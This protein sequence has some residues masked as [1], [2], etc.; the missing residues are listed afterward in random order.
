MLMKNKTQKQKLYQALLKEKLNVVM[1]HMPRDVLKPAV[2]H[3][4]CIVD[5]NLV[6][7]TL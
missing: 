2:F 7:G 6:F 4:T 1:I 3:Q 5:L